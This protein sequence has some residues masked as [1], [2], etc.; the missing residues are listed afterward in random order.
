MRRL[1]RQQ[2]A[3]QAL[4]QASA[5]LRDVRSKFAAYKA[6]V[7]SSGSSSSSSSG[8][9]GGFITHK[10]YLELNEL[11]MRVL[12]QLDCTPCGVPELRVVRK[13]LAAAA[14]GLLD[15]IQAAFSAAVNAS[16]EV[17][18][19]L[20]EEAVGRTNS[21]PGHPA[22]T[23]NQQQQQEPQVDPQ[24]QQEEDV[25][26]EVEEPAAQDDDQQQG[27]E[28][29]VQQQGPADV[30]EPAASPVSEPVGQSVAG[31][32][33]DLAAVAADSLQPDSSDRVDVPVRVVL[34]FAGQCCDAG[35]Q[36]D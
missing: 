12:L 31:G 27:E 13:R 5:Q 8:V 21:K 17:P 32:V 36:T 11:A 19:S 25:W 30:D 23:P 4:M 22:P 18:D 15:K 34:R 14:M 9:D 2:P 1:A 10:Q 6:D 16:M 29:P 28:Q 7:S 3:L 20:V 26:M 35:T 24:Q 33:A